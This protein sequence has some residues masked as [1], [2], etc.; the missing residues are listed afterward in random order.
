MKILMSALALQSLQSALSNALAGQVYECCTFEEAIKGGRRDFDVA[1]VSRDVTGLS[2]K[3]ELAPSLQA[4]YRV[5][6][7]TDTLRWVHI[8]SAGADREVYLR[9]K[10]KGVHI[11]TSSGANAEV[12]AQTALAGLLALSRKFPQL[13]H[14]MHQ[15]QWAPLLGAELPKDLA[16][17]HAVLVGWGPIA[18]RLAQFLKMLSLEITV[19]RQL[20]QPLSS[21]SPHEPRMITFQELPEALPFTNWLILTCPLTETT[22][23]LVN[24]RT[25]SLLPAGAG[26]V[27]VSRGEVVVEKELIQALQQGI[28]GSAF[29]DVFEHEPL[30]KNSPLWDLPNVIL[31]PHSAGFS[32]GNEARVSQMFLKNL[33]EWSKAIGLKTG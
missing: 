15:H 8:H 32:A 26:L 30:P 20:S 2:T 17:Q 19:V 16:G 24:A 33:V 6:E 23:G 18:Q 9:L 12:V 28:L 22:R 27:N 25:L 3:H 29:L 13:V 7:E 31:T 11:A 5:L 14:A 21:M 4:C 10:A 1:F